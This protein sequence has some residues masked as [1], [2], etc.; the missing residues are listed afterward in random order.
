MEIL[1]EK[2]RTYLGQFALA[3]G[4]F[5]IGTSDFMTGGLLPEL[6]KTTQVDIPTAGQ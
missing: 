5:A 2:K 3:L 1:F 6:A 4:G